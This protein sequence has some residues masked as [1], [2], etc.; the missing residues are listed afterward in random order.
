MGE[1]WP[2]GGAVV[3][4]LARVQ[5]H[6]DQLP[7]SEQAERA[8]AGQHRAPV[9]MGAS[10]DVYRPFGVALLTR[11]PADRIAQFLHQQGLI[12]VQGVQALEPTLQMGLKLV[13]GN[14][15]GWA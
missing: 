13:G 8:A 5:A 10:G 4:G 15:H 2:R 11:Y 12:A 9:E 6:L 7:V 14:L 1:V 3:A